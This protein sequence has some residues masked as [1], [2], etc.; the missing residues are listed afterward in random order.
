[1]LH[2]GSSKHYICPPNKVIYVFKVVKLFL[3]HLVY[4]AVE[5][6]GWRGRFKGQGSV[7]VP[8]SWQPSII[9]YIEVQKKMAPTS[10][11]VKKTWICTCT[12]PFVFT[13]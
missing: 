4:E 7:D 12:F 6:Y 11:K 1:L 9:T 10:A 8:R 5:V 13:A 2:Y 3:K